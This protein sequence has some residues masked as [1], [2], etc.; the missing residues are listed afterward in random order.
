MSVPW[1]NPEFN[2]MGWTGWISTGPSTLPRLPVES[3]VGKGF[4]S[5]STIFWYKALKLNGSTVKGNVPVNIAYMF[6]PLKE[7]MTKKKS[8][9]S[10]TRKNLGLGF[11]HCL[12]SL[13]SV[14]YEKG[15]TPPSPPHRLVKHTTIW[16]RI[17]MEVCS[18][19]VTPRVG[20]KLRDIEPSSALRQLLG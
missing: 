7:N 9:W 1:H 6:T 8:K 18:W 3:W 19:R 15:P 12:L 11:S 4:I 14:S 20:H 17:L 10:G 5:L 2:T 13:M 16:A